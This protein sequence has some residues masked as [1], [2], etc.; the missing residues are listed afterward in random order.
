MAISSNKLF[1]RADAQ[2]HCGKQQE[3]WAQAAH[4]ST[5]FQQAMFAKCMDVRAVPEHLFLLIQD[6]M[7]Q[8]GDPTGTGRGG[9]CIWGGKFEVI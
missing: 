5:L 1:A 7:I 2:D 4:M 3:M 9:E 8:A 6:F